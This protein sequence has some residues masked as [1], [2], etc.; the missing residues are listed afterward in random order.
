MTDRLRLNQLRSFLAAAD[1][2]EVHLVVAATAN[3][4]CVSNVLTQFCPLGANRVI[5]KKLDEAEAY[6]IVLNEAEACRLPLSYVSA[7]QDVPDDIDRAVP[8]ELAKLIVGGNTDG[9]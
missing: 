3:R 1:A 9:A 7:G 5:D 2:D 6:G 4:R 8:N